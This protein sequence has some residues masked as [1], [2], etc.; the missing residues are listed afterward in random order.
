M[1]IRCT[2]LR[3]TGREIARAV[4]AAG[5]E[6]LALPHFGSSHGSLGRPGVCSGAH[7]HLT[8]EPCKIGRPQGSTGVSTQGVYPPS[9]ALVG[10]ID[11]H[12]GRLLGWIMCVCV[13]GMCGSR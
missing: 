4:T 6:G 9:L 11:I 3:A 2:A 8:F 1:Y 12:N 13:L 10:N 5:R 7:P